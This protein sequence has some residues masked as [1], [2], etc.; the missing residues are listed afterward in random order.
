[1]DPLLLGPFAVA[2]DGVLHPCRPGQE[3]ALRFA[4][5]GRGCEARI[6]EG[7]IDLA[8]LAARIPST[9]ERG[10]DRKRAFAALSTLPGSLPEGWRMQVLPDHRV[11]LEAATA[12]E[13]PITATGLVAALVRFVLALDPYLDRL[14]SEGVRG[15]SALAA[16]TAKI[17]PG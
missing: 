17:C 8:A 16:G 2:P 1:M 6:G 14:E 5:R 15:P 3:P 12:L 7:G 10:A 13:R 4:W 9:A 11:R